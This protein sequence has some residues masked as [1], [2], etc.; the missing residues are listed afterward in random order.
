LRTIAGLQMTLSGCPFGRINLMVIF[1]YM[2]VPS[3]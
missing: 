2:E 1:E 3:G